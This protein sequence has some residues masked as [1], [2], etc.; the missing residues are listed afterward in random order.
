MAEVFEVDFPMGIR[1]QVHGQCLH[2]QQT[3][4]KEDKKNHNIPFAP[5]VFTIWTHG[6]RSDLVSKVVLP[7]VDSFKYR[8]VNALQTH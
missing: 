2:L 4:V 7:Q 5:Q 3:E 1:I 6:P 8:C